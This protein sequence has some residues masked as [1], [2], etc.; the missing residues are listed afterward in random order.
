MNSAS[1]PIRRFEDIWELS[2]SASQGICLDE[3]DFDPEFFNLRSGIAGEIFQKC[4]NYRLPLA[5]VL[6]EPAKYGQRFSELALEHRTHLLI[7]FFANREDAQMW[8]GA[9]AG[10]S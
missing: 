1:T 9:F 3:A 4:V 6:R 8:L 2:Q 7:R 10:D 5:I